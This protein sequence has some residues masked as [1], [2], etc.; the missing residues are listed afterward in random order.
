MQPE[1]NNNHFQK[2]IKEQL[3]LPNK[4]VSRLKISRQRSRS[5]SD[6][7]VT[8]QLLVPKPVS[9]AVKRHGS[10]TESVN[11]LAI[12]HDRFVRR[13]SDSFYSVRWDSSKMNIPHRI[14]TPDDPDSKSLGKPLESDSSCEFVTPQSSF[15]DA[16]SQGSE[17]SLD[18][19]SS[20]PHMKSFDAVVF[21]VLR[22]SPDEFASQITLMDLPV[23]KSILPDELTSCAWT[24]K[25]KLIKAPNVVGFTRR[26]NHVNFWVQREI[27]T[28][29][30]LKTRSD[31]LAHYIKIA[32]KLLD[33][34][35]LHA[36]MAVLSALQS[37]AIFRLSKTWMM[38]SR[39]DKSTYE[40][41]ADLF[42]ENSNRQKLRDYMDN[43]KHPC[44][45]Y[46]GLYL[47]DLIYIDVAHP[48]SGGLESHPRRIQMNNILRV[49]ADLQQSSYDHLP[50]LDHVQNY[51][52]SVRYIEEL[53][54]FV[55]D[56]NYKLS[57]K[58]EPPMSTLSTSK[59]D[60][61]IMV[62]PPSPATEPRHSNHLTP[63]ATV[64]TTKQVQCHRKTKS[65]SANFMSN[66]Q[67]KQSAEKTFSL[68]SK[69]T[70]PYIQ[71]IRHLLDDS[72]LEE[73]PCASSDGSICGKF[74]TTTT[75][76]SEVF[77]T[78]SVDQPEMFWPARNHMTWRE[79]DDIRENFQQSFTCEGCLRRKTILKEGKKPTVTSWTRYWVAL[80]GTSLLYYPAKSLRG[81]DRQSF[82][83]NPSK[84]TS[85][86]GW[87][88]VM[89]DNPLQPDAFQLT[90]PMKGNVYKFRGG[91][92]AMALTWCRHLSEATKRFQPKT[93]TNL[94]SFD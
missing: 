9:N 4:L 63:S 39:R 57:L 49:I 88:V 78:N 82:K 76:G 66:G 19:H 23:F 31:V 77:D 58:V 8:Q 25:E 86:V 79:S 33:L 7:E 74:S 11:R 72:V 50:V 65:L 52:R 54:K 46:L 36:V 37:A 83:T 89:G 68:P 51:L 29:Q 75:E 32:K 12:K 1:V 14:L 38:L 15:A 26:F 84:M 17:E 2:D 55:E 40:K 27:L 85:V 71:G 53:Q 16:I 34:N 59:E 92:Q 6:L 28:C 22:V 73:S 35:N 18:K 67:Q 42:S 80:W 44:V 3:H 48:H 94:M 56:D 20:L 91:S 70:A 21:D 87:M 10:F 69:T 64:S 5:S 30:T 24:T 43:V 62:A 81:G 93:P 60:V 47:T 90:D 13:L 41:I 45:P 61:Q